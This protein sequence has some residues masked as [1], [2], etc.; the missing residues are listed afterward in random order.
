[1]PN[2]DLHAIDTEGDATLMI[3]RN[4]GHAEYADLISRHLAELESEK[5]CGAIS[6]DCPRQ[7]QGGDIDDRSDEQALR[8]PSREGQQRP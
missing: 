3:A 2:S 7:G 1:L 8:T 5:D 4:G 6:S